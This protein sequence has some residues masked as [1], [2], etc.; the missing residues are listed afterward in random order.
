MTMVIARLEEMHLSCKRQNCVKTFQKLPFYDR[1]SL[2]LSLALLDEE[3]I[4]IERSLM[5]NEV[6]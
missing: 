2:L 4:S 5:L 6:D 1:I 3:K